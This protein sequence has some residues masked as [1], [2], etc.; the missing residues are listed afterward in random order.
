LLI[1]AVAPCFAVVRHPAL[2]SKAYLRAV[3]LQQDLEA[4]PSAKRTAAEYEGVIREYRHV[5]YYD[6]ACVKAPVAAQAIGDLYE[7]MGHRFENPDDFKLAIK[8]YRYVMTQYPATSMATSTRQ[9]RLTGRF[10]RRTADPRC[11][12]KR[13]RG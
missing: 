9:Q 11:A 5:Y 4:K 1:L 12:M 7:E 10:L 3:K 8:Y 13:G 2:A 6:F